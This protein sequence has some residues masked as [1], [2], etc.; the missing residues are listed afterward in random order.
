MSHKVARPIAQR[1]TTPSSQIGEDQF[2][3]LPFLHRL[4]CLRVEDFSDKLTLVD[5]YPLLLGAGKAIRS[6]LRHTC[7]VKSTR[8]PCTF[9]TFASGGNRG[10]WLPCMDG[11]THIRLVHVQAMLLR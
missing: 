3:R 7:M 4:I 2:S 9:D 10:P 1:R 6:H 5:M 11:Y 8:S